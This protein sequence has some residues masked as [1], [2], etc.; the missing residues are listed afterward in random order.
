MKTT[1]PLY[2]VTKVEVPIATFTGGHDALADPADVKVLL[3]KIKN[4][5]YHKNVDYW[6][7]LDFIWGTDAGT[8]AYKPIID[9][10]HKTEMG[11]N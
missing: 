7:H 9:L 3:P 4:H 11:E 5:I 10:I 8:V 2:D 6:D 1:P